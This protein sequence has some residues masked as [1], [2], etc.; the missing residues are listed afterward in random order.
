[1]GAALNI[2]CL[3]EMALGGIVGGAIGGADGVMMG[4]GLGG[5]AGVVTTAVGAT[6]MDH[7]RSRT[8]DPT[9]QP[10]NENAYDYSHDMD[11]YDL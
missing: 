10:Q 9:H 5:S 6:I 4:V 2:P 7:S 1:M 3:S 11:R 8:S